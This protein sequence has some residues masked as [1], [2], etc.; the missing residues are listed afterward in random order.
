VT[1]KQF[2]RPISSSRSAVRSNLFGTE[3]AGVIPFIRDGALFRRSKIDYTIRRIVR[4]NRGTVERTYYGVK[5]IRS[6]GPNNFF[7]SFSFTLVLFRQR[8]HGVYIVRIVSS[9]RLRTTYFQ[10]KHFRP[11]KTSISGRPL[12]LIER[13]RWIQQIR[14]RSDI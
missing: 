6:N 7:R 3:I 14:T 1:T 4:N 5:L 8:A 12:F 9:V 2:H 13:T 11:R 10:S